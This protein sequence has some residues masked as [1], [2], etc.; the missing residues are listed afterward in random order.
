MFTFRWICDCDYPNHSE[1]DPGVLHNK[2]SVRC[3]CTFCGEFK[4]VQFTIKLEGEDK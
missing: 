2:D 4:Q 1:Y 3:Q